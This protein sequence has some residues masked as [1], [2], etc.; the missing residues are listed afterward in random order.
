MFFLKK[1]TKKIDDE[2]IENV[3][4][5]F[6]IK[7]SKS[8][9]ELSNTLLNGKNG[10]LQT[11]EGK[12]YSLLLAALSYVKN[13]KKVFLISSNKYLSK[14]D[15]SLS[16]EFFTKLGVKASLLESINDL[17]SDIIYTSYTDLAQ[18]LLFLQSNPI[19]YFNFLESEHVLLVDELDAIIYDQGVYPEFSS[20]HKKKDMKY[21]P[22]FLE[23]NKIISVNDL[24]YDSNSGD[25]ELTENIVNKILNNFNIDLLDV[26]KTYY[27]HE[28]KLFL[29]AFHILKKNKDYI[30]ENEIVVLIDPVTKLPAYGKEYVGGLHQYV[31]AKE[32]VP[33]SDEVVIVNDISVKTVFDVFHTS[34][35]VS[36]TLKPISNI[37]FNVT[38]RKLDYI[39]PFFKSKR[40]IYQRKYFVKNE[41][42]YENILKNILSRYKE[43]SILI[44]FQ[45]IDSLLEF[46][47]Y[48]S[49]PYK[50]TT[51]ENIFKDNKI[52]ESIGSEFGITLS[53][54][55]IGRGVQITLNE[56]IKSKGIELYLVGAFDSQRSLEQAYGRVGRRGEPGDVYEILSIEDELFKNFGG[57]AFARVQKI[58]SNFD[59]KVIENKMFDKMYEKAMKESTAAKIDVLINNFQYNSLIYFQRISFLET[60]K[61]ILLD[62]EVKLNWVFSMIPNFIEYFKNI[63]PDAS[64][65]FVKSYNKHLGIDLLK[66]DSDISDQIH[67]FFN[68][69]VNESEFYSVFSTL[70]I[71]ILDDL[72]NEHYLNLSLLKEGI[73]LRALNNKDPFSEY[74]RDSFNMYQGFSKKVAFNV[75]DNL[76]GLI[77]Y[78]KEQNTKAA[79]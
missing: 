13:G 76:I 32:K 5:F 23:I 43:R 56:K 1:N 71:N 67:E 41:Y 27:Y 37:V 4:S 78:F 12:T 36:A 17:S 38:G 11:G 45:N 52:L 73:H 39:K 48:L 9:I 28:F 58:I 16:V 40:K 22:E 51:G 3:E 70:S 26:N 8:Q 19:L 24:I 47:K 21:Y 59:E 65:D 62:K 68:Y 20:I 6:D 72:W 64:V 63:E 61:K 31:Q 49:V 7:L 44:L 10:E 2:L 29:K 57:S 74:K 66:A 34:I 15:F 14:R 18:F 50:K 33:I 77:L 69:V 30:V 25:I 35:G 55:S 54:V 60:K 53:T 46:E 79:P 42:M 75:I